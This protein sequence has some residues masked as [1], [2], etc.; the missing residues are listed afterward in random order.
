MGMAYAL[1][2][3]VSVTSSFQQSYGFSSTYNFDDGTRVESADQVSA[4]LS[5]SLGLRTSPARIINI[6]MG[7][8]LTED[9]SD[10]TLGF[11]MPIDFVIPGN[12]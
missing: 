3:D 9:A 10:V 8:G 5:F 11:S 4:A 7:F 1:N 6:S 2:Y 12:E